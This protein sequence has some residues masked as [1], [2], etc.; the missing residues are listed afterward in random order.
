MMSDTIMKLTSNISKP[1]KVII[2]AILGGLA[3]YL[4]HVFF[5]CHSGG[6]PI[7]GSPIN[8]SLYGALMGFIISI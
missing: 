4:Y 8:S 2:V 3:G 1:V 6:C 7:T 5:G